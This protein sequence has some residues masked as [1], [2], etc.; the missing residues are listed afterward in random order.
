[1]QCLMTLAIMLSRKALLA[2]GPVADIRPFFS[3]RSQVTPQIEPA[4]KGAP[5]T[6][7]RTNKVCLV[8]ASTSAREL[9]GRGG[10]LL[11]LD[12]EDRRK[13]G[14]AATGWRVMSPSSGSHSAL[15]SLGSGCGSNQLLSAVIEL[16]RVRREEVSGFGGGPLG[17]S[18]SRHGWGW[19]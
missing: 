7:H 2:P 19:S 1:M 12:L 9:S 5:T 4:C 3:M 11:L 6:W 16:T 14:H 15:S 17:L 13:P 10:D 8:P 18:N